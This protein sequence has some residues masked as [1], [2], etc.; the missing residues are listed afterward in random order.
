MT[1]ILSIG[2]SGVR[3]YQ[4]ALTTTSENIANAGTAGYTRRVATLR[5]VSAPSDAGTLNGLGVTIGGITRTGN[6][7]R[8]AE[9]RTAGSDLARSEA[10]VVWLE[11]VETVLTGNKLD[12]RLTAFF[13]AATALAADP[14]ASAPRATMLQAAATLAN[15]FAATGAGL[16]GA[17]ADLDQSADAATGQ[18]NMLTAGLAKVNANLGRAAPGSSTQ[19]ALLDERDRLLESMSALADVS[20]SLDTAGRATVKAGAGGPLLVHVDQAAVATYARG[21]D[22][23]VSFAVYGVDG[24]HALAPGGGALAGISEGAARIADTR[25]ALNAMAVDFADGVNA[26]QASGDDLN[27]NP[28]AAM[29]SATSAT[30]FKLVLTDP[31]GIAAA[32]PDGGERSNGNLA[33]LAALRSESGF[34]R[35]LTTLTTNNASALTGR[36]AIAEVQSTIRANAAAARDSVGGVN[37]DEEAVDLIRFQQAYQASSRVIQVARETLDT[38]FNIR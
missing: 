27:G 32:S 7:A 31:R 23:A 8:S 16:D 19:T 17:L 13:N 38:L 21:P 11:R 26:V 6:D 15:S 33:S 20:V 30:T 4:S 5:E 22:G 3:A 14:S 25:D 35:S 12:E 28:G 9:V 2:V 37:I 18:L 10:G 36:R 29:F 24:S 34:E 1:D